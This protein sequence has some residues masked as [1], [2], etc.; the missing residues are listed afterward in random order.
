LKSEGSL[1]LRQKLAREA[2]TLLYLG[3]EKEY[4][5]AKLKAAS[6]FGVHFLPTNLEVAR[7]LDRIA[8]EN[9][10]A[11]R[12]KRL[13][14]MRREALKL[15]KILKVYNPVLIGSVW[16]GTINR[17]SDIDIVVY[18][19]EPN[20]V[21]A[22]LRQN[23]LKAL[24]TQQV[25]VTKKGQK[26]TSL[27]LHLDLSPREKAEVIIRSLEEINN[28]DKCEIFGDTAKGLNIRELE[29]TLEKNPTKRYV[30]F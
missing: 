9:E 16:R 10:G 12:R 27:H 19:D 29:K 2:A 21:L 5:Q 7:E 15:M 17:K 13:V 28:K 22:N 3:F 8:E 18:S 25:T 20:D 23:K 24:R 14:R 11:V 1:S 30:P 26:K 6:T 4:K